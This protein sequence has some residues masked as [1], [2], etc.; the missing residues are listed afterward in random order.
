MDKSG[1]GLLQSFVDLIFEMI[2]TVVDCENLAIR[3]K[4]EKDDYEFYHTRN[5]PDEFMH[6]LRIPCAEN[7]S[8]SNEDLA[9]LCGAVIDGKNFYLKSLCTQFGSFTTN[10]FQ[11]DYHRLRQIFRYMNDQCFNYGVQSLAL[12]P[13]KDKNDP[14]ASGLLYL[15][16]KLNK[17]IDERHVEKL[18]EIALYFAKILFLLKKNMRVSSKRQRIIV[19]DDEKQL[20]VM[21]E[22]VLTHYGY[23]TVTFNDIRSAYEYM[24]AQRV[25]LILVDVRMKGGSGLELIRRI[26]DQ[27]GI[28][29]PKIMALTGSIDQAVSTELARFRDVSVM[30]KPLENLQDFPVFVEKTLLEEIYF[31]ND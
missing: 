27:F 28:Y 17:N 4:N 1:E 18:E 13:L 26:R 25:D 30:K 10:Q 20:C 24:I 12:V 21:L 16:D 8:D 22:R 19:V 7:V 15:S 9:C 6:G 23:E 5:L 31:N 3:I 11:L 2:S 29:G 14:A